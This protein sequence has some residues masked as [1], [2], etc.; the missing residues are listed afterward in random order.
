MI[1]YVRL[2]SNLKRLQNASRNDGRKKEKQEQEVLQAEEM[3][4]VSLETFRETRKRTK[5][6]EEMSNGKTSTEV[7]CTKTMKYLRERT[8]QEDHMKKEEMSIKEKEPELQKQ[9]QWTLE[10]QLN[11]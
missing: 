9:Q 10:G 11:R 5:S 6:N 7:K 1:Q 8:A 4:Q 2:L 3:R